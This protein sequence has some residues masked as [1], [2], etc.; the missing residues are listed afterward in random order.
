MDYSQITF[1]LSMQYLSFYCCLFD[2]S[3]SFFERVSFWNIIN[4]K[5]CAKGECTFYTHYKILIC[6]HLHTIILL[7]FFVCSFQVCHNARFIVFFTYFL[8]ACFMFPL[9]SSSFLLANKEKINRKARKHTWNTPKWRP[10][11]HKNLPQWG[12]FLTIF[13]LKEGFL[14]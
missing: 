5:K 12:R 2:I 3:I 4:H 9:C 10:I 13:S 7:Y 6:C 8:Y 14:A 11:K 1:S